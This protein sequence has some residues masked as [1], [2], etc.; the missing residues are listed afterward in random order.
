MKRLLDAGEGQVCMVTLAPE[1]DPGL[2]TTR[3]LADAGVIVSA[4]H[5]DASLDVLSAAADEGLSMLTHLGNGCPACMPRH[6]NIIQRALSLS[7]GLT[8][9]F[10]ADGTHVPFFALNNYLQRAGVKRCVIVSDA[11]APAGLGPGRY[12]LSRW[13]LEIGEDMVARSVEGAHLVGSAI[14]LRRSA[15][16][17]RD[18]LGLTPQDIHQLTHLNPKS[19][20]RSVCM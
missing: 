2:Q 4:G 13:H 18:N 3:Y 8:L 20:L 7:D 19:I 12:T 11:I 15:D 16:N 9:C 1:H 5:T 17:L 6:D 10:I 14:S